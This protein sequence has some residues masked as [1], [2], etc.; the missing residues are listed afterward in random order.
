M[1]CAASSPLSRCPK[2]T[3]K[4][5]IFQPLPFPPGYVVNLKAKN[6]KAPDLDRAVVDT[7]GNKMTQNCLNAIVKGGETCGQ[8]V[9]RV[10]YY[11]YS[12]IS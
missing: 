11:S 12:L 7:M 8:F 5:N 10:T 4:N 1:A 3:H 9:D 2:E 6:F